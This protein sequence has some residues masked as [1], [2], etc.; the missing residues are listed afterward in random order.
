MYECTA[1]TQVHTG[2]TPQAAYAAACVWN[3]DL[4]S[5]KKIEPQYLETS[6]GNEQAIIHIRGTEYVYIGK[7]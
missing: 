1:K 2:A 7:V 5:W 4:P 6:K 3:R